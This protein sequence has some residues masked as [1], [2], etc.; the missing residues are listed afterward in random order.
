MQKIGV[1]LPRSTYYKTISFDIYEGLKSGLNRA[2]RED[3]KIITE[4]IGFGADKQQCYRAAEKLLLEEN[5]SL[6]VAFIGHRTAELLR[7]L[8]LAA[9][10]IL[11]VLDAGANLPNEWPTCPNIFYHSLHNSLGAWLTARKA[12]QDGYLEGA[13]VT[14]YYDGGYLQTY[15]ISKSFENSGSKIAFNHATGYQEQDF[16]MEPLQQYIDINSNAAFLSLFSGDFIQWYFKEIN[17]RYKKQNLPIYLTPF[18]L[19]E[20]TLEKSIFPSNNVSGIVTWSKKI[21]NQENKIFIETIQS[22]EKEPNIFSLIS[23]EV[24]FI[25]IKI[26]YLIYESK[27]NISEISNELQDFEFNS[28]RGKVYFNKKTNTFISN[29]YEAKL[30]ENRGTCEIKLGKEIEDTKEEFEKLCNLSLNNVTS[31]W[32]NSYTCI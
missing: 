15:S 30:I 10:K 22:T 3:I 19:E 25:V 27:K 2:G 21:I 20:T 6:I 32:Y 1:L 8:F 11:I 14:G 28:P 9:N 29:L 17:N 16:T 5:V 26:L 24:S 13:M 31:A 23:W 4:N 18:G 12:S 7:P